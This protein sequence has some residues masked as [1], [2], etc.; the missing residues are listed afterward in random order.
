[1][2]ANTQK[3][4]RA[5]TG[6]TL[7]PR[8]QDVTPIATDMILPN[9]S[10]VKAHPEFQGGVADLIASSMKLKYITTLNGNLTETSATDVATYIIPISTLGINDKIYFVLK[11]HTTDAVA[12]LAR[13]KFQINAVD[14][15]YSADTLF[16]AN[17]MQASGFLQQSA[18]PA[19]TNIMA[20]INGVT[21][22]STNLARIAEENTFISNPMTDQITIY[23]RLSAPNVGAVTYATADIYLLKG[24]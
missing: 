8:P 22:V 10:G 20:N 16:F 17:R 14:I 24:S 19:E 9:L 15:N 1:M 7:R 21:N 6:N 2:V 23:L 4:M 11:A 3:A 18:A 13:L 5:I 12:G